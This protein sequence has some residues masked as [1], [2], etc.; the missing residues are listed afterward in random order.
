MVLYQQRITYT[1]RASC[2]RNRGSRDIRLRSHC[3]STTCY[4]CSPR[5]SHSTLHGQL[6]ELRQV[7][8]V[9]FV[10]RFC[11]WNANSRF[12]GDC[13]RQRVVPNSPCHLRLIH[14]NPATKK[15]PFGKQLVI[16][17]EL[18]RRARFQ[19]LCACFGWR[20]IVSRSRMHV[21]NVG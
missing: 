2:S 4:P 7:L 19:V 6:I 5:S 1:K 12:T 8:P 9:F 21:H 17:F 20:R 15:T 16:A 10:S 18:A 14:G 13:C 11:Y 3:S